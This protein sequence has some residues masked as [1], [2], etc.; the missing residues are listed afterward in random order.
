MTKIQLGGSLSTPQDWSNWSVLSEREKERERKRERE[1]E[2]EK[3]RETE[4]EN[5]DPST[6]V[7]ANI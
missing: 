3:E 2:R 6:T 1:R 4:R 5:P 7:R